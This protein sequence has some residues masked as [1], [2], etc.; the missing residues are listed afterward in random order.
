MNRKTLLAAISLALGTTSFAGTDQEIALL[1]EQL[2][3][4]TAKI[5]K[6][7][8]KTESNKKE[9]KKVAKINS[10]AQ[11]SSESVKDRFNFSGDFRY[12]EEYIDERGK[13]ARNRNR[14]RLRLAAKA[15]VN[16]RLDVNMRL[17]TGVDNPTSGN[18][19][20]DGGFSTKD[21]GLDR[22]F[23]NYTLNDALT[24]SG[25]KMANPAYKAGKNQMIWDND[26][27]PEGLALKLDTN[28]WKGNLVGYAVEEFSGD[29]DILMFGGQINKTFKLNSGKLIA[30]LSYY[31][32]D[33]LQ[34]NLP[35]YDGNPR[36]NSVD[37]QGLLV[38]DYNLLEGSIEY[39]TKVSN[40]PFS[41]FGSYVENTE[42]VNLESGFAF[43]AH[44]GKVTT[45]GTW[46]INYTYMDVEADAVVAVFNDSNFG[47][48][49]PN[50]KGHLL[51]G[52]YGLFN[53]TSLAFAWFT[54]S[55]GIDQP[56]TTDYDRFQM[57]FIVKF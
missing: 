39:K 16:D 22:A 52:S 31:D 27:N 1:K 19:T 13:E 3:M 10:D 41:L 50:S 38:N 44:L 30:G 48:G 49:E 43:G 2:K 33:N 54:N 17:A 28:G 11:K 34:G 26:V 42:A 8:E 21:F 24:L 37:A 46:N 25:G 35:A 9:V 47:T 45:P 56:V 57:D 20:L 23:F 15:Q 4:L 14:V 53:K 51:R 7:E 55:I 29:D 6:L 36:S 12:R 32:Y 40:L 18:Q 5:E